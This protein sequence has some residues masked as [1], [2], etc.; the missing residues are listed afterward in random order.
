MPDSHRAAIE[1]ATNRTR[2][3]MVTNHR[4]LMDSATVQADKSA[5]C[6]R[7]EQTSTHS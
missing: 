1:H 5:R 2:V 4:L 6:G 3:A 7:A